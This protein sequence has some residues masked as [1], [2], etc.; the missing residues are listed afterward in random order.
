MCKASIDAQHTRPA[1]RGDVTHLAY[2]TYGLPMFVRPEDGTGPNAA[3][4]CAVTGQKMRISN[5]PESAQ[6]LLKIGETV[7]AIFVEDAGDV[8]DKIYLDDGRLVD[9]HPIVYEQVVVDMLEIVDE[10]ERQSMLDAIAGRSSP[11]FATT[12]ANLIDA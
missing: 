5:I 10:N 6:K 11:K 9:L 1:Q 8:P 3:V 4:T 2:S 12:T 7:N